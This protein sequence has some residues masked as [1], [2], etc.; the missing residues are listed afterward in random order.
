MVLKQPVFIRG[1]HKHKLKKKERERFWFTTTVEVL[2]LGLQLEV[3]SIC[4][5]LF[6]RKPDDIVKSDL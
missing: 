1:T 2:I 4:G 3:L 6:Q 5:T